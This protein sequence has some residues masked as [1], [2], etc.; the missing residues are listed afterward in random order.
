MRHPV[1]GVG[2]TTEVG[3]DDRPA[4]EVGRLAASDCGVRIGG[5]PQWLVQVELPYGR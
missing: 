5:D 1:P 3:D 4:G 2:L